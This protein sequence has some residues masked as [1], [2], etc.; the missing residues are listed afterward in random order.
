MHRAPHG[1]RLVEVGEEF[2]HLEVVW[3]ADRASLTVYVLDGECE[4]SVRLR[5]TELQLVGKDWNGKVKAVASPLSD[6][7]GGDTSQFEGTL[8]ALRGRS[9]WSGEIRTLTVRGRTFEHLPVAVP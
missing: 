8:P 4:S 2:A 3:E 1:G 7:K 9:G 6:E 5:Q